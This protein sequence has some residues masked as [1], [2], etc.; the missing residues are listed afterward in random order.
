MRLRRVYITTLKGR[1][2]KTLYQYTLRRESGLR[3]YSSQNIWR[4][5]LTRTLNAIERKYM[6]K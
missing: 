1:I 3:G 5:K 4:M 2:V 6:V